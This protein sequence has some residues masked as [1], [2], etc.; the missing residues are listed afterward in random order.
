[1]NL[2][3]LVLVQEVTMKKTV[4]TQVEDVKFHGITDSIQ[5]LHHANGRIGRWT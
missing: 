3:H 5:I 1:M 4:K 2:R